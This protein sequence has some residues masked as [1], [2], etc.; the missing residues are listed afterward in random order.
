M[1]EDVEEILQQG[2]SQGGM[3]EWFDVRAKQL[4]RVMTGRK[5]LGGMQ[6]R[7]CKATK[8]PVRR[9]KTDG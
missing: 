7:K 1:V 3:C 5:Y 9:K 4:S 2:D 6:A 8:E